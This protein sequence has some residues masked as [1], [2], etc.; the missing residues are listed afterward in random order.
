MSKKLLLISALVVLSGCVSTKNIP[1][2]HSKASLTKP[3]KILTSKRAKP[4]F[5]AMTAGKAAFGLLGAAAMISAGN[6][7]IKENKVE[8]PAYFISSELS[9]VLSEKYHLEQVESKNLIK[10]SKPTQIAEAYSNSD[11]VIDIET[12]NW[13]FAYFPT[14]WNNYRVIYS[15]KLRLIDTRDRS[16]IAEGFCSR[17]PE[18]D[19][20]APSY[21]ELLK[22]NAEKLKLELQEAAVYCVDEFKNNVLKV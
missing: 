12:I 3:E 9:K 4:D 7:I 10:G 21:D 16:V 19:G 2:D 22:K 6:D 8:D 13:S 15:A 14:D 11:W 18:E 5:S 1:I 20:Q 17:V